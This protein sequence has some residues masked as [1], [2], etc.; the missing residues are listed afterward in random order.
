MESIR[1]QAAKGAG[2][3]AAE[4]I[5][6]QVISFL[7]FLALARLLTPS[8]FGVVAVANLCVMIIQAFIYQGLGQAIIQFADLDDQ[9]LDTVF[10]I[11]LAAGI[12][13]FL[14]TLLMAPWV[15]HWFQTPGLA[16]VLCWLS[17]VFLISGLT[18]VQNNLLA[19]KMNFQALARRTLFSY[20]AG[21]IVGVAMALRGGGVWSL[22]GQ[23]L[24][25][26]VVNLI[27]LWTASDWRPGF[28]FCPRRARR[29]LIF[30][31][32][33]FW[34]DLLGLINRR[35][36]QLFIG[37]FFGP[38]TTGFYAVGSRVSMLL[39]EILAKSIARVSLSALSRLQNQTAR[40]ADA[41]CEIVE[42]Q[43]VLVFPIAIGLAVVAPEVMH[44]CFG[45]K[46]AASV[47]IMQAL[48]LACP[49]DALSG[50]HHSALVAQGRPGWS[51]LLTTAHAVLNLIFFAVAIHWGAVAVALAFSLRAILLY[52][53][54]LLALR[55]TLHFPILRFGKLVFFP[56]TATCL[57]AGSLILLRKDLLSAWP[58]AINLLVSVCLGAA[59]Y[60]FL[61]IGLNRT[62]FQKIR[63]LLLRPVVLV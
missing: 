58:P 30:G 14:L 8:D 20:F 40:F 18:D 51:S 3:S 34:V 9:Y 33:I 43:G 13:F 57:M 11:N 12:F 31:V 6:G 2:W 27:V 22:V 55:H 46:W 15:G 21:G 35:S 42:M 47:P 49:F 44:I 45:A 63:Q 52:P 59:I 7:L 19:R 39:S 28:Q 1:T 37:K 56:I 38:L 54:E 60:I 23:Q 41:L 4:G 62:L 53:V 16:G 5:A 36:D 10:C 48:L 32:K 29:L 50:A 26:A 17:P 25:I 24:T 61:I